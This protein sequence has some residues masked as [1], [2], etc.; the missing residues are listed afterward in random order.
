VTYGAYGVDDSVKVT[1]A[2]PARP[3]PDTATKP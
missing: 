3:A 2:V 1:T